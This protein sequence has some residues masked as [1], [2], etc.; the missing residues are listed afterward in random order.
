MEKNKNKMTDVEKIRHIECR[1]SL[2]IGNVMNIFCIGNTSAEGRAEKVEK[3]IDGIEELV[4]DTA[5]DLITDMMMKDP[6]RYRIVISNT[7]D[8]VTEI[9]KDDYIPDEVIRITTY[10]TSK[11]EAK[12]E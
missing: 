7:D 3:I 1:K 4:Y 11:N 8:E 5:E 12:K 9:L 6:R 10:R 2:A